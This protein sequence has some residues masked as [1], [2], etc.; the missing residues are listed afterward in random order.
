MR[1]K[2]QRTEGVSSSSLRCYEI[3]KADSRRERKEKKR[4]KK[5]RRNKEE[6]GIDFCSLLHFFCK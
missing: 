1:E 3:R 6:A 5:E 2:M 4:W